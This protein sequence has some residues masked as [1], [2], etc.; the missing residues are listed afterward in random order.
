MT[1]RDDPRPL[2]EHLTSAEKPGIV[3]T[4][5]T[6]KGAEPPAPLPLHWIR[7]VG[8]DVGL[9]RLSLAYFDLSP[10]TAGRWYAS[11]FVRKAGA[12][13]SC[14]HVTTP[15]D[16]PIHERLAALGRELTAELR[17]TRPRFYFVEQPEA[18]G[19]YQSRTQ[20]A[21]ATTFGS[22]AMEDVGKLYEALGVVSAVCAEQVSRMVGPA[23]AG[24]VA[25]A[26]VERRKP[27]KVMGKTKE[28]RLA[29]VRLCLSRL[30]SPV[31]LTNAND[32]DAVGV[33][34]G[35]TWNF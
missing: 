28:A 25:S 3:R 16:M 20:R 8:I 7:V 24:G 5:R 33:A 27:L 22:K 32:V 10:A 6:P 26:G 14:W 23:S 1:R 35:A 9:A 13:V 4:G 11:D 31:E 34:L 30:R 2:V 12:F 29:F 21:G 15:A 19:L 17:T 18:A